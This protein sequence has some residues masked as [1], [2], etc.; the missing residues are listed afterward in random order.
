MKIDRYSLTGHLEP[1]GDFVNYDDH[2]RMV[3]MHKKSLAYAISKVDEAY[4]QAGWGKDD[5]EEMK[6]ARAL[7]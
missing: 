7:I 4:D 3:E 5:S 2:V 1:N 6:R